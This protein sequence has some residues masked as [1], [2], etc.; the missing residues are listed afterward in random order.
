M[1]SDNREGHGRPMTA[2]NG[3]VGK[4]SKKKKSR[5]PFSTKPPAPKVIYEEETK[6]EDDPFP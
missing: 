5:R 4:L 1:A 6:A 2:A 3:Q